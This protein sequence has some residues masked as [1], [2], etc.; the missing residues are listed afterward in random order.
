MQNNERTSDGPEME[1]YGTA[2]SW[3]K[4]LGLSQHAVEARVANLPSVLGRASGGQLRNFYRESEVRRACADVLQDLRQAD[5]NGFFIVGNI[6]YGTINAWAN[7]YG[8]YVQTLTYKLHDHPSV[9]GK[10]KGG[11]IVRFFAQAAVETTCA[12]LLQECPMADEAGFF[13]IDNEK[14]ATINTWSLT[15]GISENTIR[16]NLKGQTGI[17][18]KLSSKKIAEHAFYQDSVIR[19]VCKLHLQDIPKADEKGFICISDIRYGTIYSLSRELSVSRKTLKRALDEKKA[20]SGLDTSGRFVKNGFFPEEDALVH[21]KFS[22]SICKAD[23]TGFFIKTDGECPMRYGT[24]HAWSVELGRAYSRI[25]LLI[26][27]EKGI[28]GKDIH[29]RILKKKFYSEEQILRLCASIIP[30]SSNG[31]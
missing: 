14:F 18:G 4:Q 23:S 8:L 26:G 27:E 29:A 24:I 3:C 21:K 30:P 9:T 13:T 31:K 22:E 2:G 10:N 25:A 7:E 19:E 12:G 17:T 11:N 20:I 16:S 1:R 5:E 15:L 6:R 28:D